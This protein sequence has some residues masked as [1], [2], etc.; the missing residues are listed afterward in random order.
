MVELAM[1][2]HSNARDHLQRAQAR[3]ASQALFAS[4]V[5]E[6]IYSAHGDLEDDYEE[7]AEVVTEYL[8]EDFDSA[9]DRALKLMEIEDSVDEVLEKNRKITRRRLLWG[10][11][12]LAALA[13][14]GATAGAFI[15]TR[16]SDDGGGQVSDAGSDPYDALPEEDT[17]YE[18]LSE[19]ADF[20]TEASHQNIQEDITKVEEDIGEELDPEMGEWGFQYDRVDQRRVTGSVTWYL[21]DETL[22]QDEGDSVDVVSFDDITYRGANQ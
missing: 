20:L 22:R 10:S 1:D 19:A 14:G 2:D 8:M 13:T 3:I 17:R 12:G 7:F 21:P 6:G 4:A 9:N 11:A 5:A 15:G 16:G 18:S